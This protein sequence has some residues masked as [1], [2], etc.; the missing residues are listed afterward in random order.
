[1][2]TRGKP[3]ISDTYGTR[4]SKT[5]GDWRGGSAA[6]SREPSWPSPVTCCLRLT[7]TGRLVSWGNGDSWSWR[8]DGP[9]PQWPPS[10]EPGVLL[11]PPLG[12]DEMRRPRARRVAP[13]GARDRAVLG[14]AG[15]DDRRSGN[16]P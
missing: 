3:T 9:A 1:M 14:S 4:T 10:P 16:A 6:S 5:R 7:R 8:D 12:H 2:R 11:A 13:A 15:A